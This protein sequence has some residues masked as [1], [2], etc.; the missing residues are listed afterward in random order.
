MA[1]GG[2]F[3]PEQGFGFLDPKCFGA[4]TAGL[5]VDELPFLTFDPALAS[6]FDSQTEDRI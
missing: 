5:D 1:L 3:L 4:G 2:L 6:L